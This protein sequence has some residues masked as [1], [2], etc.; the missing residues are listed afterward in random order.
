MGLLEIAVRLE[1][2][3]E[4]VDNLRKELKDNT[5]LKREYD[6][7]VEAEKLIITVM[8]S[9]RRLKGLPAKALFA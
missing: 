6:Q 5:I 3:A 4:E 7:L 1:A 8:N 2:V 9:L